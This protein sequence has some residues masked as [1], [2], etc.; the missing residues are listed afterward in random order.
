MRISDLPLIMTSLLIQFMAVEATS[1]QGPRQITL[2]EAKQIAWERNPAV[3]R[4]RTEQTT[5][6]LRRRQAL[7]NVLMP[8]FGSFLNFSLNRFRRY[9][10]EDF[11]GE[12]EDTAYYAEAISSRASQ[13]LAV[14]M[15]LFSYSSWV[16]WGSARTSVRQSELALNVERLRI[17]AEVER[18]FYRVLLAVDMVRLEERLTNTARERLKAE[19]ARLAAGMSLPT[20][21]L[22]AEIEL[23]DQETRL[24][25]ARGEALKARLQLVDA[26]G[27]TEDTALQPVGAL[28]SAFDPSG[29]TPDSI[30]AQAIATAPLMQQAEFAVE[31]S[32]AQ[33]RRARAFRWPSVSGSASYSRNRSTNGSS[34]FWDVN[35]QNRGYALGLQVSVPIPV[36][37]FNEGLSIRAADIGHE[38]VQA[39]YR[40]TRAS[41]QRLVRAGL[42][43]LNNG[44]RALASAQRRAQLSTER[45]RLAGEQ[46]KHGTITFVDLQQVN[47]RDAQAHRALLDA[48][49]GFTNALLVLEELLG[50][51]LRR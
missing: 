22:G 10:A 38:N 3:R 30:I 16:E 31:S 4:A 14:D 6:E 23:L 25:Q 48:R 17:G 39:D 12:L 34:A 18:R 33:Q 37:R 13:S 36:L 49:F 11:A 44:W 15:R 51:P 20:D 7:N 29:L 2:A 28:P 9:V 45:A 42:I 46:H 21:R 26:L 32:R 47:D 24:E 43:D 50:R 5:A 40:N 41:L 1:A 8:Q 27:L 19:E 35:P